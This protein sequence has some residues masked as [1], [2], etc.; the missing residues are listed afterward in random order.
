MPSIFTAMSMWAT[1]S[2]FHFF[3]AS[4]VAYFGYWVVQLLG[5]YERSRQ[6]YRWVSG[7]IASAQAATLKLLE[8][9]QWIGGTHGGS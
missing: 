2:Y 4:T 5:G 3:L 7:C 6:M 8:D 1:S 9:S